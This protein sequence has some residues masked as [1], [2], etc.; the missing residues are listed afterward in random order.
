MIECECDCDCR[1]VA[2]SGQKRTKKR[3]CE[4]ASAVLGKGVCVSGVSAGVELAGAEEKVQGGPSELQRVDEVFPRP[5]A[6]TFV[7]LER[8][9]NAFK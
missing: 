8:V 3:V 6:R 1:A 4:W 9:N 5:S 2:E 7:T